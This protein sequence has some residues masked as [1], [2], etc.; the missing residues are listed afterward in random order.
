MDRQEAARAAE[1]VAA[2]RASRDRARLAIETKRLAAETEKR[3]DQFVATWKK[4]STIARKAP[5]YAARDEARAN[6]TSM[7]KSLHRDPQ[8]ES[9]L[10]NRRA[11][12][13]LD[14]M[15]GKTLSQDLQ[16]SL[17]AG[18]GLGISM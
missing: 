11:Q 16:L 12:L 15:R 4:E 10:E 13:G 3:A 5:T 14:A 18:R 7:A 17:G 6:L 2:D 1:R 8:L 9:L